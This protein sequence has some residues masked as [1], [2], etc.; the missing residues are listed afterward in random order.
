MKNGYR[1]IHEVTRVQL[2]CINTVHINNVFNQQIDYIYDHIKSE[3]KTSNWMKV[4]KNILMMQMT[5]RTS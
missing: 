4:I 5:S 1:H 2:C 3:I